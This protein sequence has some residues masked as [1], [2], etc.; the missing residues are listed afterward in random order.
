M[1]VIYSASDQE[2]WPYS[3]PLHQKN[4]VPAWTVPLIATL[5]PLAFI[6]A[7]A[8]LHRI[9]R[10][11]FHNVVLGLFSSVLITACVTNLVKLGVGQPSTLHLCFKRHTKAALSSGSS[12]RQKN[13]LADAELL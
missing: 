4:T 8:T 5:V 9:P 6:L 10:L 7:I 3:Y 1:Q 2:Y 11:E 12:A 13:F